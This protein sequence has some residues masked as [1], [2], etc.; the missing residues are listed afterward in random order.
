[1]A[2]GWI[3]CGLSEQLRLN[4]VVEQLWLM[5]EFYVAYQNN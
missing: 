4:N 5:V 1:M 3:L 2:H